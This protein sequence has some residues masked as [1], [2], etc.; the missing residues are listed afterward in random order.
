VRQD[1]RALLEKLQQTEFEYRDFDGQDTDE[2]GESWPLLEALSRH[3]AIARPGPARS[4]PQRSEAASKVAATPGS[5]MFS[6]YD[7]RAQEPEA[8]PEAPQ[9]SLRGFLNKLAADD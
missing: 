7:S 2:D 6:R 5:R 9:P 3:P 8:E 1:A 4:W